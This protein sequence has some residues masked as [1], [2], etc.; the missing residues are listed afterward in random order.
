MVELGFQEKWKRLRVN[1][2]QNGRINWREHVQ[3]QKKL[4][5]ESGWKNTERVSE[6]QA[7]LGLGVA[8]HKTRGD[9]SLQS[10]QAGS[11]HPAWM[12]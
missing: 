3:D 12:D 9:L 8:L 6:S 5:I 4:L 11:Q 2:E 7:G 1:K 10:S